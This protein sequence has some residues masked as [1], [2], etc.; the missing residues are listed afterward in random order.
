LL[1]PILEQIDRQTWVDIQEILT[2]CHTISR[3]HSS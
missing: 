2:P 3:R 1:G